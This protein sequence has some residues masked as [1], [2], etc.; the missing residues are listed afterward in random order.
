MTFWPPGPWLLDWVMAGLILEWAGLWWLHR[1]YGLGPRPADLA[2]GFAAGLA[3]MLLCRLNLRDA[4]E[5]ATL[6]LLAASGV[7]HVIDLARRWPR[8]IAAPMVSGIPQ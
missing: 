4:I 5:P 7:L 3:L 8:A 1:R 6:L 2:A